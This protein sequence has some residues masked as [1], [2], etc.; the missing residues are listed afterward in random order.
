[1]IPAVDSASKSRQE[2]GEKLMERDQ[3]SC[4]LDQG[5]AQTTGLC[6]EACVS[7]RKQVIGA[8]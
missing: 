1:M 6:D 5:T 8:D 4:V 3:V 2:H 7:L